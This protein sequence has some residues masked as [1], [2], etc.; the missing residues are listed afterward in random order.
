[1]GGPGARLGPIERASNL[2]QV[3]CIERQY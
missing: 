3:R 1:M 2:I